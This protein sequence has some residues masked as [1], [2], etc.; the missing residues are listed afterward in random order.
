MFVHKKFQMREIL[1]TTQIS[2]LMWNSLSSQTTSLIYM[3]CA[4]LLIYGD[5]SSNS[6][7]ISF[8]SDL[9]NV[10]YCDRGRLLMARARADVNKRILC[11]DW[12]DNKSLMSLYVS[13][14]LLVDSNV[15]RQS[16]GKA[17]AAATLYAESVCQSV[18][19][20]QSVVVR[21]SLSVCQWES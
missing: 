6:Q 13:Y 17:A 4:F 9:L 3:Y 14:C 12:L 2:K 7:P 1:C 21:Q 20:S 5:I 19:R 16:L 8:C 15:C 10:E 11:C 18:V